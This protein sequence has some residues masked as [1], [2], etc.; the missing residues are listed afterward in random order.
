MTENKSVVE[1]IET[2]KNLQSQEPIIDKNDVTET[3]AVDEFGNTNNVIS[4]PAAGAFNTSTQ[5]EL[6]KRDVPSGCA[7]CLCEFEEG[8]TVT[9]AANKECHHVFHG[10]CITKW[11]LAVGRKKKRRVED[12]DTNRDT[13]PVK[14]ATNFPMLCPC[15]R[16][17]FVLSPQDDV[18]SEKEDQELVEENS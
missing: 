5:V 9:W 8:E 13:D 11:L 14:E 1:D 6:S 15:C 3:D 4:V 17:D 7:I 12:D 16:Q 18:K 2:G 10:E